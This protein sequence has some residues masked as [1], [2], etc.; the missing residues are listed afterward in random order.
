[1]NYAKHVK[2]VLEANIEDLF[3]QK[4]R[5]CVNPDKNFTRNKKLGF[6]ELIKM[7]ISMEAGTLNSEILN[8]FEYD[9]E[10]ITASA[11]IQQ[12]AKLKEEVFSDLFYK[13]NREFEFERKYKGYSCLSLYI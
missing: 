7:L 6:K 1:M 10:A 13:F 12:R 4:E 11:F 5:Y 3:S 9:S 8:Y 2:R